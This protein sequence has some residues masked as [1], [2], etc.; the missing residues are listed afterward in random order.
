MRATLI[1]LGAVALGGCSNDVCADVQGTCIALQL[2]GNGSVATVDIVSSGALSETSSTT[3]DIT[4]LPLVMPVRFHSGFSGTVVLDVAASVG[5]SFVGAGETTV[6]IVDG[7]H[8]AA[9]V[10]LGS[11]GVKL[12]AGIDAP[13]Q[14]GGTGGTG[15]FG[16]GAAGCGGGG[17]PSGFT[18]IN[19]SCQPTQKVGNGEVCTQSGSIQCM[20]PYTC[21]P[22]NICRRPCGADADCMVMGMS[23]CRSTFGAMKYCT[24]M[25]NPVP[26]VGGMTMCQSGYSCVV[27]DYA[28]S[29]TDCVQPDGKNMA[30]MGSCTTSSDCALN[31]TCYVKSGQLTGTCWGSCY[32]NGASCQFPPNGTCQVPGSHWGVCCPMSMNCL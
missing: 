5:G 22:D 10:L 2:N 6:Q 12:D 7:K 9:G 11:G 24:V 23:E 25:C 18:C 4:G 8:G 16:G 17:C 27:A 13:D 14:G 3:G 21:A 26:G 28:T 32:S 1:L 19:N 31:E 30:P 15:G 29:V 20:P